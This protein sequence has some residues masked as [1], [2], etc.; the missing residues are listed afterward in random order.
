MVHV[1]KQMDDQ[2]HKQMEI[3]MSMMHILKQV[4]QKSSALCESP[5][6]LGSDKTSPW[7][8]CD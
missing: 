6:Y 7:G 8:V 2:L 1:A 5:Y 3:C 4:R